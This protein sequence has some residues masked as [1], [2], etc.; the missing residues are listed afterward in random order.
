MDF[1]TALYAILSGLIIIGGFVGWAIWSYHDNKLYMEL[2]ELDDELSEEEY[3]EESIHDSST[4]SSLD[5]TLSL[6]LGKE[7]R[8]QQDAAVIN[9]NNINI[10]L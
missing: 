2:F 7:L 5:S 10:I 9:C 1:F 8:D 6:D 3:E 4:V